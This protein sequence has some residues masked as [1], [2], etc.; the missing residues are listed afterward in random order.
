MYESAVDLLSYMLNNHLTK[1][2]IQ[3][4]CPKIMFPRILP[5]VG[6]SDMFPI[7]CLVLN[8]FSAIHKVLKL[9]QQGDF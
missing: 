3:I 1:K 9:R 2:V 4:F 7:K 6:G 8:E 5:E